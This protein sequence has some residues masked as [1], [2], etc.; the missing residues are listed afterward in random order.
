MCIPMSYII[1][2]YYFD[3]GKICEESVERQ[4]NDTK[5]IEEIEIKGGKYDERRS[6]VKRS[7]HGVLTSINE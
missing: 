5:K 6:L 7:G 1:L 4:E 3:W 2:L